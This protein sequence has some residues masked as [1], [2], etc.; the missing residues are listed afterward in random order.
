MED[1]TFLKQ[2]TSSIYTFIIV[3]APTRD[4]R[5]YEANR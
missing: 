3:R 5:K 2:S 1:A 4:D